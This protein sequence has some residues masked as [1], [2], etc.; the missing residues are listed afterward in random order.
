MSSPPVL[1]VVMY[2]Y[3]RDLP[4]SGYPRLKAMLLDDFRSQV[5]WLADTYEMA[6][7]ESALAFLNGT[8]QPSRP[9]C[10]LTFDDGVKEHYADVLPVLAERR[11]QG[12]FFVITGCLEDHVVAPVHMNH[13]LMASMDWEQYT[14]EFEEQLYIADRHAAD[15]SVDASTAARTY[16]WDTAEVARFKYLFNFLLKAETREPIVKS[17]FQRHI[18]AEDSFAKELYVSWEEA[19]EMQSAGMVIGGHTHSHS[20]LSRMS[21]QELALDLGSC[22]RLLD[23]RCLPQTVWPFCY[24]YGKKDSFDGRTI[25][26][27]KDLRFDCSFSTEAESNHPHGDRYAIRRIDCNVALRRQRDRAA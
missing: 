21:S 6:T 4:N 3:V 25:Q 15:L 7:M 8:Y 18:G 10:L 12:M 27:L 23:E 2:H 9:L 5:A 26:T 16:P 14:K 24:P 11:I 13:F 19:R 17:L 20:V 22:R 1:D